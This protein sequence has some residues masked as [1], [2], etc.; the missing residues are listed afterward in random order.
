[1][2]AIPLR[3]IG[4][5]AAAVVF[6]VLALVACGDS[7][8]KTVPSNTG[9]AAPTTT[10]APFA[11]TGSDFYTPPDP[12]PGKAHGDLIWAQP[13]DTGLPAGIKGWRI[14]YRSESL[15][16]K[17]I[18]VSG[19]VLTDGSDS[20]AR[21]VVAWAHPTVG[22]ADAC[23]P[24]KT[25]DKADSGDPAATS[26]RSEFASFVNQGYAVVASDYEGLGTPGPH[27]FLVG[28]SE[29]R[30]VL[31]AVLAAQQLPAVN[32]G[33]DVVVYGV[34][35]GGQG[36]LFAGQLAGSWAPALKVRGVVAAAP[37]S[38][39]DLL[40]PLAASIPAAQSYFVLGALGQVAA[41]PS[42]AAT[43]LLDPSVATAA[44]AEVEKSC[45]ADLS[46]WVQKTAADAGKPL[47]KADPMQ[48]PAWRAQLASIKPGTK[49]TGAPVLVVQGEKDTTVPAATTRV[50]VK[51][52]CGNGDTVD[53]E[54]FPNAGH[55]D[56][57]VAG[58]AA[59]RAFVTDRLAG[60]QATGNCS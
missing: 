15:A 48:L 3:R 4:A 34:S 40:L 10:L 36:A 52:M 55:G 45:L 58:D 46:A 51:R 23:A 9:T 25:I 41:N 31:D 59:I 17:P 37:F 42:L 27:P 39:V 53:A 8:G 44:K 6:A 19:F 33:N 28:E 30:G 12:L 24:S 7:N 2:Q 16:G 22:S 18:A 26:V 57:V 49:P 43:D 14:L 50:L 29:G 47:A 20:K 60:K 5:A 11:V 38:E 1:M 21:P 54:Y 56:S 35:Q 13:V 32:A